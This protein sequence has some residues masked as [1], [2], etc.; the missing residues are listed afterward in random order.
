MCTNTYAKHCR[1]CV[2]DGMMRNGRRRSI[3]CYVVA[4]V[5]L[6]EYSRDIVNIKYKRIVCIY[7]FI[8]VRTLFTTLT[9]T[10]WPASYIC[11]IFIIDKTISF[12]TSLFGL[13]IFRMYVPLCVFAFVRLVFSRS[14]SPL[15]VRTI[16]L[17]LDTTQTRRNNTPNHIIPRRGPYG[18]PSD[19]AKHFMFGCAAMPLL[20]VGGCMAHKILWQ[21]DE[22]MSVFLWCLDVHKAR[23]F[24]R[25]QVSVDGRTGGG[26]RY[27]INI[28]PIP[29]IDTCGLYQ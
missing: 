15:R 1:L 18:G 6:L 17:L 20:W 22:N 29:C 13:W 24:G 27:Y 28:M 23:C 12:Y 16:A 26:G 19:K 7:K 25:Q 2:C 21:K 11:W 4:W 8:Y 3:L 14:F 5:I 10:F 9:H